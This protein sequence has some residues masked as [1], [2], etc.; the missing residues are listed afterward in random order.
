M[1]IEDEGIRRRRACHPHVGLAFECPFLAQGLDDL[2]RRQDV[3]EHTHLPPEREVD[4]TQEVEPLPQIDVE[5]RLALADDT[6]S[7]MARD[8]IEFA[9]DQKA[10]RFGVA[11]TTAVQGSI[12]LKH[13][14]KV[15]KQ[16]LVERIGALG[17]RR[18]G[19]CDRD[20]SRLRALGKCFRQGHEGK[21]GRGGVEG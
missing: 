5:Q 13:G 7:H 19:D 2:L 8:F 14:C 12:L 17:V 15:T 21:E 4:Q 9:Q 6:T 16:V 10:W 3:G 1:E 11:L 20:G 18:G